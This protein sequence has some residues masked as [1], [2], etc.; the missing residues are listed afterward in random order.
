MQCKAKT[1]AGVQCSNGGG[2]SGYCFVH[3]PAEAVKRASARKRGGVHRAAQ[4]GGDSTTIPD[5]VK[6]VA[7]VLKVLQYTLQ[8]LI[9]QPNGVIRAR[10]LI[11]CA[12]GFLKA[13]EVGELETRLEQVEAILKSREAGQ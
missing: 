3:N 2:E 9:V 8:E 5:D 11:S 7:D 6:S 4:H 10:A 1:K 13:L 12:M